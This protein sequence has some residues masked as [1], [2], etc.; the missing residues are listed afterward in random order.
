MQA[1]D[2]RPRRALKQMSGV[3]I[4]GSWAIVVLVL[5]LVPGS[6][7]VTNAP[8]WCIHCIHVGR[9][10]TSDAILNVG[11][12][13]PLGFGLRLAGL[14]VARIVAIGLGLTLAIET[15]QLGLVP[16][17]YSSLADVVTNTLGAAIGAWLGGHWRAIV[18]PPRPLAR[19]LAI[20]ALAASLT[21]LVATSGLL[22]LQLP[23]GP[24][25]VRDLPQPA[26]TSDSS[27][28]SIDGVGI[29]PGETRHLHDRL[30]AGE[31]AIEL[32]VDPAVSSRQRLRIDGADGRPVLLL[33]RDGAEVEFWLRRN[34][35]V[36]RLRD[37]RLRVRTADLGSAERGPL[38]ILAQ[39]RD[40]EMRLS[41]VRGVAR[42][43]SDL[44][45]TP[46]LGWSFFT[47][48][49]RVKPAVRPW[50]TAL[51]I[52]VL[53]AP[54]GYWGMHGWAVGGS[55][56]EHRSR[57][58][59]SRGHTTSS[60]GQDAP[61]SPR[62]SRLL[63][64]LGAAGMLA[65]ALGLAPVVFRI[66]IAPWPEWLAATIGLAAGSCAGRLACTRGSGPR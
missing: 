32:I 66:G 62:G 64:G 52:V 48:S 43:S 37:P 65:M 7:S 41:V 18:A 19:R 51:W 29:V 50:I 55:S 4:A 9:R 2:G 22:A 57:Q 44:P 47:S 28:A 53:I 3:A 16:G 30:A 11:L 17:R 10:F 31:R 21:V 63:A 46:G 6:E 59:A 13:V 36:A 26:S 27:G 40:D 56:P 14:G 60:T 25:R 8:L 24:Y 61:R 23:D 35:S 54:I 33:G 49:Y 45:L 42:V 38:R 20:A 39:A 15:A 58:A 12:F 34:A 5:T 1:P